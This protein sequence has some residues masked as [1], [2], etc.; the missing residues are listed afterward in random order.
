M[1]IVRCEFCG[2][3]YYP[4]ILGHGHHN[5]HTGDVSSEEEVN[6]YVLSLSWIKKEWP[7]LNEELKARL[8]KK[9]YEEELCLEEYVIGMHLC[10]PCADIVRRKLNWLLLDTLKSI[11]LVERLAPKNIPQIKVIPPKPNESKIQEDKNE[12]IKKNIW[13]EE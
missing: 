11:V 1:K 9:A 2:K 13:K 7:I 12:Q 3:E 6:Q 4:Q 8:K 10:K 5:I